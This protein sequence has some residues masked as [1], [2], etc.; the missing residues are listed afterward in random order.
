MK[1]GWH[2]INHILVKYICLAGLLQ[3]I[4]RLIQPAPAF[5]LITILLKSPETIWPLIIVCAPRAGLSSP[6]EAEGS[7]NPQDIKSYGINL[8]QYQIMR[9]RLY[10]TAK[11]LYIY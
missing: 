1:S 10:T 8:P 7:S 5:T 3:L 9:P 4:I 11:S 2:I 6:K